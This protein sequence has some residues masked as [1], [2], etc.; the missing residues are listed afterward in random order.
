MDRGGQAWNES[1]LL[2][3]FPSCNASFRI[4]LFASFLAHFH[5]DRLAR[6]M[7]LAQQAPGSGL[8]IRRI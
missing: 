8:W 7:P 1:Y 6:E 5:A 2:R 3:A 4:E